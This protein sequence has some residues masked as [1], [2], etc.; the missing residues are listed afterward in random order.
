MKVKVRRELLA[1]PVEVGVC[2]SNCPLRVCFYVVE[3]MI[4]SPGAD[5]SGCSSKSSGFYECGT[6]DGRGCP[7]EDDRE[8]SQVPEWIRKK[9]IWERLP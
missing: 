2:A 1:K 3:H 8:V 9:G 6:R 5:M 4:R 7:P